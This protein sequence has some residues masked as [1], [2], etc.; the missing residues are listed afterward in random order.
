[1]IEYAKKVEVCASDMWLALTEDERAVFFS[2]LT[3]IDDHRTLM[4]RPSIAVE[5]T[6]EVA[7]VA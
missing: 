3:K 7:D 6:A 2:L 1:M 5:D 4:G